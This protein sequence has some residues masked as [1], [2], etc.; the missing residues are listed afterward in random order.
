L[1]YGEFKSENSC[2]HRNRDSDLPSLIPDNGF[3]ETLIFMA[4]YFYIAG[5][6][7]K[8]VNK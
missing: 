5:L 6:K 2:S 4:H 3:V 7:I 1:R 8:V